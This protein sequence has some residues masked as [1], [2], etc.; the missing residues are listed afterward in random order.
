MRMLVGLTPPSSGSCTRA[1][2]P[3][4]HTCA[5]PAGT[6]AC[7]STPRPSIPAVPGARCC[8]SEP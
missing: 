4:M 3:R 6:W 1:G 8:P 7:C 5:I 2:S